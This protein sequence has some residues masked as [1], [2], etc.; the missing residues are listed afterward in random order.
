V[1]I[2]IKDSLRLSITK[3]L[4][5][6]IYLFSADYAIITSYIK[7]SITNKYH[8]SQPNATPNDARISQN[9]VS[10]WFYL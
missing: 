2:K 6:Y 5:E 7:L 10:Q 1:I 8:F 3:K 4:T 9:Q